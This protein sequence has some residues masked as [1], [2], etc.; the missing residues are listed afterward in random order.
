[1][2]AGRKASVLSVSPSINQ[3]CFIALCGQKGAK[4]QRVSVKG[5]LKRLEA[6]R[7]EIRKAE[8]PVI[9]VTIIHVLDEQSSFGRKGEYLRLFLDEAGYKKAREEEA[10]RH[11]EIIR[12]SRVK[13]RYLASWGKERVR[14]I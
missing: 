10:A 3:S 13:D 12:Y 9:H 11:I 5:R 2:A 4:M 14:A 7:E 8:P 1:M 6:Q